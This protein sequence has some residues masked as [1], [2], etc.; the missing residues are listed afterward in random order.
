[1]PDTY[2]SQY[3]E[4]VLAQVRAGRSVYD[5]ADGLEVSAATIFRW[6]RKDQ[7]DAGTAVGLSSQD[8]AELRAANTRIAELEKELATVKRASELFLEGRVVRPKEL[9]PI[10]EQLGVE[11]HGLKSAWGVLK[12]ASSGF[13]MWRHRPPSARAIRRAW[14]TDVIIQIWEQSRRTYGWRR[15]QAELADAY[16]HVA[17]KKLVRAIMSE[18][19]ISGPPKRRKG[20]RNMINKATSTDL[21]NRDF[22]R[23]GPNMLWMTD[24]TEHLTSEGRVFCC[25]VLD[26][27]SRKVVG[28]SIDQRPTTA[29]V[30][31]ALGMAVTARRPSEG[32]TLHSDHGPQYTA[33]AFSQ[34]IR[35]EGLVHSLGTVGDAFDNAMVESFWG[36]MQTELLDRQKWS[37]R[38]ELSAA[39]FDWI[40]AFYNPTRRHS[41]LG[42][43]SPAEFER[44]HTNTT[45]A[46]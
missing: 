2:S 21:V 18:Q 29:M 23:D 41:A 30:N 6:K 40:E 7:I 25:V 39:M 12:I 14:L 46:A 33:W 35:A 44:R 16:D 45:T 9:F 38:L 5:L 19:G 24:I 1:M 15:V 36:R 43:I 4:M 11:G 37:T 27:W 42:N 32:T 3:R 34:K 20:R 13:F 17:N 10:V 26:A 31:S 28:W 8:S 22:N